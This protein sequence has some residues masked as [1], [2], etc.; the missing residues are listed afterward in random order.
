M[1]GGVIRSTMNLFSYTQVAGGGGVGGR[2]IFL[3]AVGLT[4][5]VTD[6]ARGEGSI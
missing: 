6:G 2:A 3:N 4:A 5:H 1:C